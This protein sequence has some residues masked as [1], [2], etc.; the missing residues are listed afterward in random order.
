MVPSASSFTMPAGRQRRFSSRLASSS[1]P[2]ETKRPAPT[3]FSA[4][5]RWNAEEPSASLQS[6][7][8]PVKIESRPLAANALR[9]SCSPSKSA[10]DVPK[11]LHTP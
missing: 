7:Q 8:L 6:N 3:R 4:G 10:P 9:R 2:N 5:D 1:T 11:R